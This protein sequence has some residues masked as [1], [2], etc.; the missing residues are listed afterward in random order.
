MQWRL[1]A[2]GFLVSIAIGF[3]ALLLHGETRPLTCLPARATSA[4]SYAPLHKLRGGRGKSQSLARLHPFSE[5]FACDAALILDE[6]T[7]SVPHLSVFLAEG[8][9]EAAVLEVGEP[10]STWAANHP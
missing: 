9:A 4:Y 8:V 6:R 7:F 3:E 10:P 5:V 1:S 2:F